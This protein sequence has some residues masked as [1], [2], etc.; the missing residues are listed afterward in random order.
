MLIALLAQLAP[1]LVVMHHLATVKPVDKLENMPPP[2]RDGAFSVDG[3]SAAGWKMSDPGG[4]FSATDVPVPGAPAR[5]LL[6]GACDAQFCLLHYERGGIAHFYEI[7]GF[8]RTA[9]AWSVVWNARGPKPLADLDALRA[10][11]RGGN[12]GGWNQQFVKGD[13]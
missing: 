12:Y 7:L 9:N 3:V 4:P 2:I 10:L 8:S 6:F 1:P 5:R 11:L 13:F